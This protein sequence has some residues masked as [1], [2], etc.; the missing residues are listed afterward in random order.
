MPL[1]VS[2]FGC[3]RTG[4]TRGPSA[5]W[6]PYTSFLPTTLTMPPVLPE[7]IILLIVEHIASEPRDWGLSI[8][9]SFS[10][11]NSAFLSQC[12]KHIFSN[13]RLKPV[14][15]NSQRSQ[16][17]EL[18]E[19]HKRSILFIK[20]VSQNP[21]LGLYVQ[22]L[23]YQF[24]SQ[25]RKPDTLAKLLLTVSSMTNVHDFTLASVPIGLPFFPTP[26]LSLSDGPVTTPE[27]AAWRCAMRGIMGRPCLKTLRLE[28]IGEINVADLSLGIQNLYL[29]RSE[30]I[31]HQHRISL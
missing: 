21:A 20:A 27:S 17:L 29:N 7:D 16:S 14:Y 2:D 1:R 15:N 5:L 8:L 6:A 26:S 23:D 3:C 13:V 28:N 4:A 30:L 19:G 11:A 22:H 12:Q 24:V 9:L 10:L 25:P 18:I 31:P